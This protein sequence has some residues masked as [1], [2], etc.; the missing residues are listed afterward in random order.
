MNDGIRSRHVRGV[1]LFLWMGLY[2]AFCVMALAGCTFPGLAETNAQLPVVQQSPQ[3]ALPSI[4]FPQDEGVHND[5]TEW[6]YYTGHLEAQAADGSVHMYGFELVVFQAIRSD[7][8]VVYPAHFAITDLT[9]H[10]FHYDQRRVTQFSGTQSA[11]SVHNSNGFSL[12]VGDWSLQGLNGHDHLVA[13]MDKY[14]LTL[15]LDA[16]KPA[17]LHNDTGLIP[18]GLGGFSYYYSRTRMAVQGTLNDHGQPLHVHGQAWMDHQWGNFLTLGGGWD[19]YSLQLTNG[20]EIMLY[21]IRGA[22]GQTLTTYIDLIDAHG[23]AT[24]IPARSLSMR[25]LAYWRSPTTG[26]RYPSGWQLA[27]NDPHLRTML[28]VQPLLKNQELITTRSTGNIYWEGAVSIQG[29]SNG[30]AA[31]GQGYVELTGYKK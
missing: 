27:I 30:V 23:H 5:L 22:A 6:W 24:V 18:Y 11:V 29:Q 20:T 19:W 16:L 12:K 1:R 2:L 8:P 10:E 26:I 17:V 13:A 7:L 15:Q 21:F 25:V 4:Q 14:A 31:S 3:R 28:T 9:R